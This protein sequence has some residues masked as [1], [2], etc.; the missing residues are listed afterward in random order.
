MSWGEESPLFVSKD[1]SF[2][3]L[4]FLISLLL[5]FRGTYVVSHFLFI[6]SANYSS[7]S[8]FSPPFTLF[9]TQSPVSI[10]R[11][12]R[13]G[14]TTGK[15][16]RGNSLGKAADSFWHIT[17]PFS[18]MDSN[19]QSPYSNMTLYLPSHPGSP[20]PPPCIFASPQLAYFNKWL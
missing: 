16:P 1:S 18:H 3:V 14:V 4:D 7:L 2:V 8:L 11:P 15:Q 12:H 19:P 13:H 6:S 5:S 17:Q 20:P 10:C 9:C